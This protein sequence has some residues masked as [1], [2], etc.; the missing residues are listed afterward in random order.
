MIALIDI[1]LV[2][3]GAVLGIGSSGA[4]WWIQ[5]HVLTPRFEFSEE[6]CRRSAPHLKTGVMHQIKFRNCGRRDAFNV[7]IRVRLAIKDIRRV[8]STYTNF[9]T[10]ELSN[11]EYF[12]VRRDESFVITPRPDLSPTLSEVPSDDITRG[13][14][15]GTL[16]MDDIYRSYPHSRIYIQMIATDRF[17]A[18]LRYFRSKRYFERDVRSG[19]FKPY[20]LDIVAEDSLNTTQN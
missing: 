5:N 15:D 17:S 11:S 20:T 3:V 19:A 4:F 8:G 2:L 6:M 1:G 12:L 18:S 13:L 7:R 16:T 9:Y 14:E 10:L